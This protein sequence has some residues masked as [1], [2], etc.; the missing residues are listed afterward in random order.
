MGI[1]PQ[2]VSQKSNLLLLPLNKWLLE[3]TNVNQGQTM[4]RM[5]L[6]F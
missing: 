4:I 5:Y 3:A 2:N 1:K 6:K